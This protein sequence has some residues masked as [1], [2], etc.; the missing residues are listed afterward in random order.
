MDMASPGLNEPPLTVI[1]V[2]GP[3]AVTSRLMYALT[4]VGVGT[5]LGL[6]LAGGE[7]D[8]EGDGEASYAKPVSRSQ[9]GKR[10]RTLSADMR[11]AKG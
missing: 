7:G 10:T 5:G 3:P 2:L 9:R 11:S 6:G 4:G 1:E 8:A